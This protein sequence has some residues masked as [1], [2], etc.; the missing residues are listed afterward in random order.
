MEYE[1]KVDQ[2]TRLK[3]D[4]IEVPPLGVIENGKT[5]TVELTAEQASYFANGHGIKVHAKGKK[6]EEKGK[7]FKAF[8]AEFLAS[9]PRLPTGEESPEASEE[10]IG[11]EEQ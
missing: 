3:G 11:G 7:D 8:D 1:I 5:V 10:G 6:S 4:P 9:I 2:P